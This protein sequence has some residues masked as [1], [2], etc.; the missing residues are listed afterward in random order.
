MKAHVLADPVT[1][2]NATLYLGDCRDLLPMLPSVDAVI[3]DPPYGLAGKLAG[4]TWG[5]RFEGE[6]DWDARPV[7][8][9]ERLLELGAIQVVWGGNYYSLPASRGWLSWQKP[10]A[11]PSMAHFELAWTN[12]DQNAR[13]ISFPLGAFNSERSGHPTQKPEAVMRWCLAEVGSPDL[14]LDPFMGSGTTGVAAMQLGKQ[15]IGI[16]INPAYFA[17]ACKR[18]EAAQAQ[19]RLFA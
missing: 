18:I 1:I 12:L 16:E 9:I 6:H 13:Q 11:P 5:K 19:Q 3:T 7:V 10:D 2:G 14:I 4:G 8:G 17:M 15:F